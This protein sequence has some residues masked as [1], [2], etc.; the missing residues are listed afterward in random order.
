MKRMNHKLKAII[1]TTKK[2]KTQRHFRRRTLS[3]L[4]T[5]ETPVDTSIVVNLSRVALSDDEISLL[6]KRLTFCPVPGRVNEDEVLDDLENYFRRLR[7][8]EFFADQDEAE[9][10]EQEHFRPR[11]KRMPPKGRDVT[12]ESYGRESGLT[13]TIK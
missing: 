6:S 5:Q 9:N 2:R 7:L 3:M 11:R 4:T 10:A 1:S 12:L 13:Y 8:T